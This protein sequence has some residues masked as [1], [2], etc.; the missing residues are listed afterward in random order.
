G[1]LQGET[2][3]LHAFSSASRLPG[4][5]KPQVSLEGTRFIARGD[6]YAM[7]RVAPQHPRWSKVR[8]R[9][10]L[11]SGQSKGR[12]VSKMT[13]LASVSR[14]GVAL[15]FCILAS[16]GSAAADPSSAEL[17]SARSLF[18]EARAAEERGDWNEAL[19]KLDA[20]AKVKLT[21]QVRF[22][23]GLCQEHLS[24]L[25]ESLNNLERAAS[26]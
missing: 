22:H 4:C 15:A 10:P 23:L 26:E 11:M 25:L 21:P 8:R 13:F 7:N 14:T 1:Y 5:S 3:A 24:L 2:H 6:P 20:V 19:I 17:A 9:R 16:A 18:N 12:Y